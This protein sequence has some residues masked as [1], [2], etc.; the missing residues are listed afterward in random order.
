MDIELIESGENY[1]YLLRDA[2]SGDVAIVDPAD[3]VPVE[4]ILTARNWPLTH[5]LNTHHHDDG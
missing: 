1:M 4:Q 5:I 2:Q 3:A